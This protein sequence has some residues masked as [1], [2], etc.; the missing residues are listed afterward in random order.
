MVIKRK[1]YK[2]RFLILQLMELEFEIKKLIKEWDLT[3]IRADSQKVNYQKQAENIL[4]GIALGVAESLLDKLFSSVSSSPS[5]KF[6]ELPYHKAVNQFT[7]EYLIKNLKKHNYSVSATGEA[8]LLGSSKENASSSLSN[9]IKREFG[10]SA[11]ELIKMKYETFESAYIDDDELEASAVQE[12]EKYCRLFNASIF[13][14]LLVNKSEQ[15]AKDLV[16]VAKNYFLA[17]QINPGFFSEKYKDAV[18]EFKKWYLTEQ[19]KKNGTSIGAAKK[20]GLT[21]GA[22]RQLIFRQRIKVAEILEVDES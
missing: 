14:S 15:I 17:E 12:M 10:I 16:F 2:W 18:K 5:K 7:R 4:Y 19:I 9:I 8:I 3:L 11:R 13:K 22:F 1:L 21:D 20:S 6:L